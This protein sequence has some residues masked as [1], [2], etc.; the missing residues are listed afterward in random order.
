MNVEIGT[1][2]PIFLFWEYLFRI[3][4]ILSLQCASTVFLVSMLSLASCWGFYWFCCWSLLPI[5]SV[6]LL[7]LLLLLASLLVLAF[8][9]S[10]A[11]C[12]WHHWCCTVAG[13]YCNWR[14]FWVYLGTYILVPA[15][16]YHSVRGVEL[17]EIMM[18]S[19]TPPSPSSPPMRLKLLSVTAVLSF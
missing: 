17:D 7:A 19:P 4:G 14:P 6:Q 1:E 3:F 13:P 15:L 2:T 18:T 11:S 5:A 8:M 16:P 9:L 12:W 10:L